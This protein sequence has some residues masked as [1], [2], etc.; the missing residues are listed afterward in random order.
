MHRTGKFDRPS[1]TNPL[2]FTV[3]SIL[4]AIAVLATASCLLYAVW[5]LVTYWAPA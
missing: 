2:T 3:S 5:W 1:R 4:A